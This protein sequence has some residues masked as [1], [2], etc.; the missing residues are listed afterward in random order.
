MENKNESGDINS[1][2]G[3]VGSWLKPVDIETVPCSIVVIDA[4]AELSPDGN[5][6]IVLSI[7]HKEKKYDWSLNKTNTAFLKNSGLT[8]PRDVIGKT[9]VLNKTKVR[10][11]KKSMIVDSLFIEKIV[12]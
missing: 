3:F 4:R 2:D 9:L 6:Q 10:D 11:P 7:N 8:S 5:P 1:W 12:S